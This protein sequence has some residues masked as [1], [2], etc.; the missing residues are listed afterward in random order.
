M[1]FFGASGMR[2]EINCR[3]AMRVRSKVAAEGFH[4]EFGRGS[5]MRRRKTNH[6]VI[7]SE[8]VEGDQRA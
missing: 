5:T 6:F 8:R 1:L 7:G 3:K 2:A 4:G